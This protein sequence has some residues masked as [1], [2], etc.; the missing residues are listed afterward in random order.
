MVHL[1]EYRQLFAAGARKKFKAL[2]QNPSERLTS[3]FNVDPS[4]AAAL[5]HALQL[6]PTKDVTMCYCHI[7]IRFGQGQAP[8]C[9]TAGRRK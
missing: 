9:C 4:D 2:T 6:G 1:A 5:L 8:F 7:M 3:E